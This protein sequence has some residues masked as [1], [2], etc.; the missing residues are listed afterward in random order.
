MNAAADKRS[1]RLA[2]TER[3]DAILEAAREVFC[4]NG[5]EATTVGAIAARVGVVEGTI[6]KHFDS[7]RELLL[8]VLERWYGEL[9]DDYARDLAGVTGA[10]AQLRLLIWRHL[11]ALQESPRLCRLIF[12]EIRSGRDYRGSRLYQ[13]NRRYT[14]LLTDALRRGVA[15]GELR[16]DLPAALLR[17]LILGGIEHHAWGYL[18]GDGSLDIDATAERIDAL[19]WDGIGARPSA[20]ERTTSR[21]SQLVDRLEHQLPRES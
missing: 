16:D 15:A 21:L 14:E 13:L 6:Y 17:D 12:T 1:P 9:V 3:R 7:K 11:R 10:R 8:S 19:L 2:R 5:Y 18:W 4:A 20:L